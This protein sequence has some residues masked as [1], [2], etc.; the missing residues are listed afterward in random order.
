MSRPVC[1]KPSGSL[2][3]VLRER[4][5]SPVHGALSADGTVEREEKS[6][7]SGRRPEEPRALT[8]SAATSRPSRDRRLPIG[9][10]SFGPRVSLCAPAEKERIFVEEVVG[11]SST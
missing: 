2:S 6:R 3:L 7:A 11:T 8:R 10:R 4:G 9:R 5:S 1:L